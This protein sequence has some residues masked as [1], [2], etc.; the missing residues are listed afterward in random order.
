ML[1]LKA[2]LT[3][4]RQK[5]WLPVG[6]HRRFAAGC[7]IALAVLVPASMLATGGAGRWS[8]FVENSR[9]YLKTHGTNAVGLKTVLAYDPANRLELARDPALA[10]SD[11]TWSAARDAALARRAWLGCRLAGH[12]CPRR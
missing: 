1:R 8:E 2:L 4:V 9:L 6:P 12:H 10:D 11:E 3:M 5:S 7:L